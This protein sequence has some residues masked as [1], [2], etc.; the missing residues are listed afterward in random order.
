M[1]LE[2]RELVC[3][4]GALSA[5]DHVNI[6]LEVG[7][8][9]GLVGESGC[10]KTTLARTLV[11][12]RGAEEGQV[13]FREKPLVA[14]RHSGKLQMV[15]QDP[16]ASLN[17]R[18]TVFQN[19]AMPLEKPDAE[20]VALALGRVELPQELWHRMPR[21]LSV[22][23]QQRVAIARAFIGRPEFLVCDEPVSALDMSARADI[24]NLLCRLRREDGI[25]ML[26]I[27][28]DLRMVRHLCDRIA[29]MDGGRFVEEGE[30]EALFQNPTHPVTR[31]LLA[32]I[33]TIPGK[34]K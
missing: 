31:R 13:F 6:A 16:A 14:G 1:L 18:R 8:T 7:E 2:G 21:T 3:R 30:N 34:E 15:F 22:G 23:Q 20:R 24:I 9:L 4:Y 28:H 32:A 33:P 12:L 25:A 5:V 10:G 29:V 27:S 26:V 17:P 19:V 11:G